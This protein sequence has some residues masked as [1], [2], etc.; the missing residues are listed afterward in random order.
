MNCSTHG[1]Q[2]KQEPR[3]RAQTQTPT[4][5]ER[6]KDLPPIPASEKNTHKARND[7]RSRRK[8]DSG[9]FNGVDEQKDAKKITNA[10]AKSNSYHSPQS[11]SEGV[12][13]R[14]QIREKK[15]HA[16]HNPHSHTFQVRTIAS[17]VFVKSPR[18]HK[19]EAIVTGATSTKGQPT[20]A[21]VS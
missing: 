11:D 21:P 12:N 2:H 9:H 16:T 6:T 5:I 3:T 7:H 19:E 18:E 10:C 1:K 4:T 13:R 8:I 17:F 15:K 14:F 20:S